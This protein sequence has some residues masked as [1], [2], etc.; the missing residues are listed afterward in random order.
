MKSIE[1]DGAQALGRINISFRVSLQTAVNSLLAPDCR[2]R[3]SQR[4]CQ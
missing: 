1:P 2:W 3:G 4:G